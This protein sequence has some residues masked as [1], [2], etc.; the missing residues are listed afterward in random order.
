[1][2]KPT[3]CLWCESERIVEGKLMAM[4]G[5]A[6]F[7]PSNVKFFALAESAVPVL[8]RVCMDCG[9]MDLYASP[10]HL[11]KVVKEF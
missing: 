6:V 2:E 7:R 1:M 4:G 10:K 11:G 9:Y 5:Q 3:K 8:A